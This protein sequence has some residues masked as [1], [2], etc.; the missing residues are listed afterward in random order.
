MHTTH[1]SSSATASAIGFALAASAAV[2]QC[3]DPRFTPGQFVLPWDFTPVYVLD[4]RDVNGDGLADVLAARL[5]EINGYW[6][7]HVLLSAGDGSFTQSYFDEANRRRFPCLGDLNGDSFPD[8]VVC[9]EGVW[10]AHPTI[11]VRFN[12]GTGHFGS[13]TTYNPYTQWSLEIVEFPTCIDLNGDGLLDLVYSVQGMMRSRLNLGGGVLGEERWGAVGFGYGSILVDLTGDGIPELPTGESGL[14]YRTDDVGLGDYYTFHHVSWNPSHQIMVVD[15][16]GDGD[17][18]L[19]AVEYLWPNGGGRY[20]TYLNDG[21]GTFSAAPVLSAALG[22]FYDQ[23]VYVDID[24][25][26]D[27]DMVVGVPDD[28][29]RIIRYRN[30]GNGAF[31]RLADVPAQSPWLVQSADVNGDGIADLAWHIIYTLVDGLP[32]GGLAVMLGRGDG[33]FDPVHVHLAQAEEAY[34][35]NRLHLVDVTGDQAPDALMTA[36]FFGGGA[37]DG[38]GALY[39]MTD[40]C[41]CPADFDGNGTREVADI[42]AFLSAWF[43]GEDAAQNFGG[44]PGVP[45]I[46]AFLSA[47]FAG[48]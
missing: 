25:D 33:D 45:A 37:G 30:V 11:E 28:S 14:G 42:F 39:A 31:E 43:A 9:L 2:A 40:F 47:W 15:I 29:A 23:R 3:P 5:S 10:P 7:N 8:L 21:A 20:Y 32:R 26:G 24:G 13:P 18:D 19:T 41:P 17:M 44:T 48:C 6:T 16:D 34:F 35:F 12:D 27:L 46:F 4:T 36:Y 1:R 22:D 38:L